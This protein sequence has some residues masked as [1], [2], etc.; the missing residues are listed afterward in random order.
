MECSLLEQLELQGKTG[1][2][3]T[4]LVSDYMYYWQLKKE[5]I[6][7][8]KNKGIRYKTVNGNGISVDKANESVINLPKTTAIMLKIL[9]DLNLKIPVKVENPEDGYM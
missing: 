2:F 3:Y 5:L 9:T 6:K 1:N 4:D 8:I 7:D